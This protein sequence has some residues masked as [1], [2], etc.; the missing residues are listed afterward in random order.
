MIR[1]TQ[2]KQTP[3]DDPAKLPRMAAQLLGISE[4]QVAAFRI[5]RQSIDAR[6]KGNPYYVYTVELET[7]QE[8]HLVERANST[9]ITLCN[10]A[11]PY[12]FPTAEHPAG[13]D[14][15]LVVG[16]G[17]AGLF[18]ALNLARAGLACTVLERGTN[19]DTRSQDVARFWVA[20]K[21]SPDSNVQFGEGG[22]GAFSDG[23]LTTGTHDPRIRLVLQTLVEHGAPAEILY[24]HKP[25]VGTDILREVVKS[26]RQE[27][28]SLGCDILFSHQLVGLQIEE[29][30]LC[31]AI[32][33]TADGLI[34]LPCTKLVLAPGHSARDTFA[35]LHEQNVPME[36]KA[37]AIGV[38]IEH[39]QENI[40]RAQFGESH[41]LLPPT[42]YKLACHLPN[43]RS[44]F[45]FCVCP[46]GEVVAAASA[47]GQVVTNGMS[48][49]ARAGENIN[50]GF[51]VGVGPEDYPGEDALAGVRF[52]EQ[53]ERA[54]WSLGGKNYFAPAQRVED[55]LQDRPSTAAGSI[56]P[57]YRPGVTFTN[58]SACLPEAVV[59]TLRQALPLFDRKVRGFADPD[60]I[61]TGVETRSSSPLRILRDATSLSSA[62]KGLYP[63]GEGAGYAGGIVSA[64]VDGVRVAEAL[65]RT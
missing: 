63:C 50:G 33:K 15:P 38:R 31:A 3:S 10:P 46:G 16:M 56:R 32:V 64:A 54:A 18:A 47:P 52:Q 24:S 30:A 6:K 23:K 49:H 59:E 12:V 21:L 60:A 48:Y 34:T 53:W 2:L 39:K 45:T 11:E 8:K 44:A 19:V 17:P 7:D 58:L 51:L 35:M 28:L 40:S 26:I 1:I 55:F 5:V 29:G 43:G 37:F 36:Q 9:Q 4:E 61:L 14:K 42:D 57:S 41:T 27:L 22:A 13:G 62:I 65:V 25:H 20:G